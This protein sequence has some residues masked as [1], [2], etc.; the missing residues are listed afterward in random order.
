ML[1]LHEYLGN[2][3]Y[4]LFTTGFIVQN[5]AYDVKS[6]PKEFQVYGWRE[7][8]AADRIA[9]PVVHQLLGSFIYDTDGPSIQTFKLSG[10]ELGG[11]LINAVRLHVLSNHGNL[12][13]TCIYRFRVHGVDPLTAVTAAR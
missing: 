2:L 11:E 6:A 12:Q 9:H 3:Q 10:D 7:V 4:M 13:H 1:A 5:A 8:R